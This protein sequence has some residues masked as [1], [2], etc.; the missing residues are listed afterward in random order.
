[1]ICWK[2]N[3]L[4]ENFE[5]NGCWNGIQKLDQSIVL[6]VPV[7]SSWVNCI[8]KKLAIIKHF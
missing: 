2:M 1:M 4:L 5:L 7:F 8:K 3:D 6:I